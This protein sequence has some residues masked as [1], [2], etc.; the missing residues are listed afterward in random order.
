MSIKFLS[1]FMRLVDVNY[2]KL[3]TNT[4]L[5]N[6]CM[7]VCVCVCVNH[8]ISCIIFTQVL[9]TTVWSQYSADVKESDFQVEWLF[10]KKEDI[11]IDVHTH[12]VGFL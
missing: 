3:F 6:T 7:F 8:I 1:V 11:N 10:Y 9:P 12:I 2:E 4:W 5:G